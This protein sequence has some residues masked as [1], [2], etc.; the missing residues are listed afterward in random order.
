[1]PAAVFHWNSI[2]EPQ[3]REP[4]GNHD[5]HDEESR[6]GVRLGLWNI[7][8]AGCILHSDNARG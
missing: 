5:M 2:L 8:T 3:A 1:M 4:N 7:L 6:A